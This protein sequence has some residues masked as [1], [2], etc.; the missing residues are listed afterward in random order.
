MKIESHTLGDGWGY[1]GTRG[2]WLRTAG[3][4]VCV[5]VWRGGS[6]E[7]GLVNGGGVGRERERENGEKQIRT[8][9]LQQNPERMNIV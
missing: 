4:C 1:P 5:C 3:V 9:V 6:K 2:R 8:V 7:G